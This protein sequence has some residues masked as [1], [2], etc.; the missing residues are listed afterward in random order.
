MRLAPEL[1]SNEAE[2]FVGLDP[3]YVR[4][5]LQALWESAKQHSRLNW[6][7]V[8]KLCQWV[9]Q[10]PREIADRKGGIGDQDPD[11]SWTRKAVAN[12]LLLGFDHGGIPI[13]LRGLAWSILKPLTDDPHPDPEPKE[14]SY[15]DFAN[16]SINTVRGE[17]MHAVCSYAVWVSRSNDEREGTKSRA[18]RSLDEIPEVREILEYHLDPAIDPSP[19]I[20]A[21]YGQW[22]PTLHYLDPV[23]TEANLSK[24]FPA[25]PGL[26]ILR[27]AAWKTYVS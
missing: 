22:L 24:I 5:M 15:Q 9:V 25:E 19:T 26:E 17:A 21:V 8:L 18:L 7:A 6:A 3:T 14:S 2:R 10:Q 23:W 16:Y 12:L 11:W 4:S 27:H 20:R 13:E 1:F